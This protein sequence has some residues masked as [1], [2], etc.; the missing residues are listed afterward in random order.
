MNRKFLITGLPRS[1]TAWFSVAMRGKHSY[2]L[3]EPTADA[4][5]YD[6]LLDMWS[7]PNWEYQGVS[8]SALGYWLPRIMR[9]LEPKVLIVERPVDEVIASLERMVGYS[10]ADWR[11]RIADL[12]AQLDGVGSHPLI[13]R[14]DYRLLREPAVMMDCAEWLVPG[15][16]PQALSLQHMNIQQE[17]CHSQ[18]VARRAHSGWHMQKVA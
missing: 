7:H 15:H 3:H 4:Q 11:P 6:D 16:G 8:D 12:K 2:C 14:V 5:S 18:A 13:K 17:L 1:R 9:D 10:V